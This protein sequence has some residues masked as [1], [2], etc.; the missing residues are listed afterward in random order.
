M[1]ALETLK[2]AAALINKGRWI[3]GDWAG[4]TVRINTRTGHRFIKNHMATCYCAAG[5]M[6]E[7]D[8]NYSS[9]GATKIF[10]KAI[11]KPNGVEQDIWDW[12]DNPRRTFKQ[13]R[14]A[15]KRAVALAKKAEAAA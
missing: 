11:R 1:T 10:L 15:F 3:K 7:I 12:N 14:D 6:K 4:I 13:V 8:G 2:G 9:N 5:A